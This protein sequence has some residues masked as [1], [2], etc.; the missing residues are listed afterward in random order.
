MERVGDNMCSALCT[1]I[2]H[3]QEKYKESFSSFDNKLVVVSVFI[4]Y[5]FNYTHVSEIPLHLRHTETPYLE[6]LVLVVHTTEL[7]ILQKIK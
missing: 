3:A 7:F 6:Q 4:I 1:I 5:D 2:K